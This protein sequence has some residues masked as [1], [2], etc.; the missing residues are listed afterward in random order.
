MKASDRNNANTSFQIGQIIHAVLENKSFAALDTVSLV[1]GFLILALEELLVTEVTIL[2]FRKFLIFISKSLLKVMPHSS[3]SV[4]NLVSLSLI[5]TISFC[6]ILYP[7]PGKAENSQLTWYERII[8]RFRSPQDPG[9]MPS[10]NQA[11]I[12]RSCPLLTDKPPLTAFV[13][14]GNSGFTHVTH[15]TF[16]FYVPYASQTVH[17]STQTE[18]QIKFTLIEAVERGPEVELYEESFPLPNE[19][20]MFSVKLPDIIPP[21]EFDKQYRWALSV[22][23]QPN[24]SSSAAAVNGWIERVE[25]SSEWENQLQTA[26]DVSEQLRLYSEEKLWYDMIDLLVRQHQNDPNDPSIS[27]AWDYVLG[28]VNLCSLATV[29]PDDYCVSESTNNE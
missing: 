4:K 11:G 26:T 2:T 18:L 24:D 20:G 21:L 14:R 5:T 9:V 23:C 3:F 17:N 19:P 27:A 29:P 7:L 1:R 25:V 8:H 13:T 22:R 12:S 6:P 15:P 28:F 16:W 10:P